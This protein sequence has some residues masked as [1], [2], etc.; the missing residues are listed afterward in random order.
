MLIHHHHHPNLKQFRI[1]ELN[2]NADY[3]GGIG[4]VH[5]V[6]HTYVVA[7]NLGE[8]PVTLVYLVFDTGSAFTWVQHADCLNCLE[9]EPPVVGQYNRSKTRRYNRCNVRSDC[10][11]WDLIPGNNC[12]GLGICTYSTSYGDSTKST[13]FLCR[14][15][16]S[17]FKKTIILG[18][19]L[20]N[21][22]L[23][24]P[25]SCFQGM[26]GFGAGLVSIP[27]QLG[28][29]RWG[30]C[31]PPN[32]SMDGSFMMD[33]VAQ[34]PGEYK[35]ARLYVH[36]E[37]YM[38]NLSNIFVQGFGNLNWGHDIQMI[39]VDTGTILTHM[40]SSLLINL[41]YSIQRVVEQK[42]NAQPTPSPFT[43]LELCYAEPYPLEVSIQVGEAY[44]NI[45]NP[46]LL[47]IRLSGVYCLAF[48]RAIGH[49]N[50]L[51]SH[52]FKGYM[53]VYD[54]SD[55]NNMFL[56]ISSSPLNDAQEAEACLSPII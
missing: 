16:V 51:G 45:T 14:E 47:W 4:L 50:I 11:L 21:K 40:R 44:I 30:F 12:G 7:L 43:K 25:T 36:S 8:D 18:I 53:V 34:F 13:G 56:S 39:V 31:L 20:D 32:A 3:Y 22:C 37:Y 55:A 24:T 48:V 9:A 10:A 27:Y 15:S 49:E 38:V 35:S 17:T 19:G 26:A 2:D 5:V 54:T 42:Y 33:D 52:H 41:F 23:P 28:K 46:E 1:K 29:T 6:D